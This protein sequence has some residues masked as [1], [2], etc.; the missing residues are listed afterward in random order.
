MPSPLVSLPGR[1][2]MIITDDLTHAFSF[3]ASLCWIGSY[4]L[5]HGSSLRSRLPSP[6]PPT[7][8]DFRCHP[9]CSAAY[10]LRLNFTPRPSP[11]PIILS[12]R[13]LSKNIKTETTSQSLR[14]K[15]YLQP[16]DPSPSS[17]SPSSPFFSLDSRQAC[18][19]TPFSL[20]EDSPRSRDES[21][22]HSQAL[23]P[24][25]SGRRR[26]SPGRPVSRAE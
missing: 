8:P 21:L 26:L 1:P 9:H 13:S 22:S 16:D 3:S 25:R 6:F 19:I 10:S 2:Q 17:L 20:H 5:A 18:C 15:S 24:T 23:S 7:S 12:G 4:A 11:S 14:A